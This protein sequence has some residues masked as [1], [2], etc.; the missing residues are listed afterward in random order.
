MYISIREK[1]FGLDKSFCE[2]SFYKSDNIIDLYEPI[3]RC[4]I[5]Y[6]KTVNK[7]ELTFLFVK[8]NYRK[9]GFG[10]RLMKLAIEN[11]TKNNI[12]NLTV[13]AKPHS[14]PY[15]TKQQLINFYEKYGFKITEDTVEGTYMKCELLPTSI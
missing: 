15:M 3:A 13:Y 14:N 11:A 1:K 5:S 6:N 10:K 8:E 7:G 4:E 9:I 12:C 2:I